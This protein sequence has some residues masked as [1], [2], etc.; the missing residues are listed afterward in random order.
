MVRRLFGLRMRS[1]SAAQAHVTYCSIIDAILPRLRTNP[2]W[3]PAVDNDYGLAAAI[4]LEE[5]GEHVRRSA[6]TAI[7]N[8]HDIMLWAMI[9]STSSCIAS[10]GRI[11]DRAPLH[12][13]PLFLYLCLTLLRHCGISC[14]P[15][16]SRMVTVSLQDICECTFILGSDR[17]KPFDRDAEI[18][19]ALSNVQ[20]SSPSLFDLL[21]NSVQHH[22]DYSALSPLAPMHQIFLQL[23]LVTIYKIK[24]NS[25]QQSLEGWKVYCAQT[26]PQH[27]FQCVNEFL[28]CPPVLCTSVSHSSPEAS[29]YF[30][31]GIVSLVQRQREALSQ[32]HLNLV[33]EVTY[34]AC[35][36]SFL[37]PYGDMTAIQ[38][39]A[40][41]YSDLLELTCP[42]QQTEFTNRLALWWYWVFYAVD[43]LNLHSHMK[44]MMTKFFSKKTITYGA[45][46]VLHQVD[47]ACPKHWVIG[48]IKTYCEGAP[49]PLADIFKISTPFLDA[50]VMNFVIEKNSGRETLILAPLFDHFCTVLLGRKKNKP[51]S[52][53]VE[54]L[55][56]PL[57]SVFKS[58][59]ASNR[60]K[61]YIESVHENMVT[62]KQVEYLC[63][64][65]NTQYE[66]LKCIEESLF[67]SATL[68]PI[69]TFRSEFARLKDELVSL[70][71][72]HS[73]LKD[74]HVQVPSLSFTVEVDKASLHDLIVYVEEQKQAIHLPDSLRNS[75]IHFVVNHS[76]FFKAIFLKKT[77][78]Q[79]ITC[80]KL[81]R[82]ISSTLDNLQNLLTG[83]IPLQEIK[84]LRQFAGKD[85]AKEIQLLSKFWENTGNPPTSIPNLH[86]SF[87]LLDYIQQL[88][89]VYECCE[90]YNVCSISASKLM[91]FTSKLNTELLAVDELEKIVSTIK[92]AVSGMKP[93]HLSIFG[94]IF[95]AED[96][97]NWYKQFTQ[98][99]FDEKDALVRASTQG[100]SF[101]QKLHL[102][103]VNAQKPLMIFQSVCQQE[104]SQNLELSI[105]CQ[106]LLKI[107]GGDNADIELIIHNISIVSENIAQVKLMFSQQSALSLDSLLPC[108]KKLRQD[109]QYCS[110]LSLH[111]HGEA[112][113]L[114]LK[115]ENRIETHA[116]LVDRIK[117]WKIFIDK[118]DVNTSEVKQF[119][120]IFSRAEK[121]HK[122]RL[123][124]EALGYPEI[125][126]YPH[127]P[128][129][130][131]TFETILNSPHA[132]M[133][134]EALKT[135]K[136]QLEE[137]L[138]NWKN[139]LDEVCMHQNRLYFL[140]PQQITMFSV[141]L[142]LFHDPP[143]SNK[144]S[145][146]SIYPYLWACFPEKEI[147][148]PQIIPICF[149][150]SL[151]IVTH[152]LGHTLKQPFSQL[153]VYDLLQIMSGFVTCCEEYLKPSP[154]SNIETPEQE[155][156]AHQQ[157]KIRV[158][159]AENFAPNEQLHLLFYCFNFQPPHP[160]C[161]MY[162]KTTTKLQIHHFMCCV[163]RFPHL[164]FAIVGVNEMV[165][166][167]RNSLFEWCNEKLSKEEPMAILFLI[168]T[169]SSSIDHFTSFERK[170]KSM[171]LDASTKLTNPLQLE[172]ISVR[173]RFIVKIY[174]GDARSGK[175]TEI[176]QKMRLCRQGINSCVISITEGFTIQSARKQLKTLL[177]Q[178]PDTRNQD[179]TINIH[180][181]IS[182]YADF[183]LV[184]KLMYNLVMW[185][186][187]FDDKT[188]KVLALNIRP[189]VK[190]NMFVE[191]A[192][193]PEGEG[194]GFPSP[195]AVIQNIA[196][197]WHLRNFDLSSALVVRHCTC[198][199][200]VDEDSSLV[201]KFIEGKGMMRDIQ[202]F[203]TYLNQ[204]LLNQPTATILSK[205]FAQLH[206]HDVNMQLRYQQKH[207]VSL[208]ADRCK[209]LQ[210]HS[211]E[212]LKLLSNV[213]F[214][215][216]AEQM[217]SVSKLFD[218]F[219]DESISL[220]KLS[221][222]MD[223]QFF[224]AREHL[225]TVHEESMIPPLPT[226]LA[227]MRTLPYSALSSMHILTLEQA[228][229][230]TQLRRE[231]SLAFGVSNLRSIIEQ[232]QY[233]LTPDFALK[234]LILYDHMKAGHN[235]TLCGGT[236]TGKTELLNIFSVIINA[237]TKLVPDLLWK[238]HKFV[239][240]KLV[241]RLPISPRD[242]E[243]YSQLKF[244]LDPTTFGK[245]VMHLCSLSPMTSS[246]VS[247]R[248]T[249]NIGPVHSTE[250]PLPDQNT[251]IFPYVAHHCIQFIRK[252][253]EKNPHIIRSVLLGRVFEP[254][255]T[256]PITLQG[257]GYVADTAE[258][259]IQILLEFMQAKFSSFF[260]RIRMHQKITADE[261][262]G[263]IEEIKIRAQNI[264]SEG[265]IVCFIDECTSTNILGMIKEVICDCQI[266][267][268]PLPKNIFFTA[269]L[270]KNISTDKSRTLL[271][272]SLNSDPLHFDFVGLHSELANK[273]FAVR[274]PPLSLETLMFDFGKFSAQQEKSFTERLISARVLYSEQHG[275]EIAQ[276]ILLGQE[277]LRK[278]NIHRVTASIRDIVRAV[279]LYIYF[280][281]HPQFMHGLPPEP[282][283][284][285]PEWKRFLCAMHWQAL[286]LSIAMNYFFRLP[287]PEILEQQGTENLNV[288]KNS[289]FTRVKFQEELETFLTSGGVLNVPPCLLMFQDFIHAVLRQVCL[290]TELPLGIAKTNAFMENLF[291]T[292][293][294]L[295]AKIPLIIVGPPGCSKTLSFKIAADNMKGRTSKSAFYRK[296]HH[297][298][299][300]R[301]QCS[302]QSTDIEIKAVYKAAIQRENTFGSQSEELCAVML[303]EVGLPNEVE[304]PLKI[305]HFKLDHPKV[306]SVLLSNRILDEAK[307]NR[308]LMLLQSEPPCDDL[309]TLAE[310]CL[311]GDDTTIPR[312][313]KDIL[314]GLCTAYLEEVVKNYGPPYPSRFFHLR[315]F[316]Y[317]LRYLHKYS[318]LNCNTFD[319]TPS[320][321]YSGLRRNFGG[322]DQNAFDSL[323]TTFFSHVNTAL[324]RN[325]CA[326]WTSPSKERRTEID[327]LQES[328][329]E[330]LSSEDDPNTSAFRYI[331]LLDP[332]DNEV[333]VQ[334]LFDLTLCDKEHTTV[335]HVSDFRDD[336]DQRVKATVVEQVK[337]AM[338]TGG[339]IILVNSTT[340]H[341]S[342]YDVFN[343]H[344]TVMFNS[345]DERNKDPLKR[346]RICYANLAAGSFTQPCIVHDDFR[347]IVHVP[348]NALQ[349][350]PT[351]LLNRFEKYSLS[352]DDALFYQSSCLN[353]K[354]INSPFGYAPPFEVLK[355]GVDR[356]VQE[357]H[358]KVSNSRLLCG[359]NLSETVCSLI[360]LI[361]ERTKNNA[362]TAYGVTNFDNVA[363]IFPPHLG[364]SSHPIKLEI[365]NTH[366]LDN[367]RD[368]LAEA[369]LHIL[370]LAK[371][372]SIYFCKALPKKYLENYLLK[373]EHFSL[374]RFLG[375][376]LKDRSSCSDFTSKWCI[377][378]RTSPELAHLSTN[379]QLR[380]RLLE[381]MNKTAILEDGVTGMDIFS[382]SDFGSS[383]H[384]VEYVHQFGQSKTK[385]LLLCTV[386]TA[387]CSTSQINFLRNEINETWKGAVETERRVAVV[388]L[389]FPPEIG[390]VTGAYQAIFQRGWDFSYIDSLGILPSSH[391][392]IEDDSRQTL[393]EVNPRAWLTRA[394]G[395]SNET[396]LKQSTELGEFCMNMTGSGL[397]A[398]P[399]LTVAEARE[400][401]G[402]STPSQRYDILRK[403]F[404][405]NPPLFQGI[406]EQF[407]RSWSMDFL[408][409]LVHN[410]SEEICNGTCDKSFVGVISSS[411]HIFMVP[412]MKRMLGMMLSSYGLN[413]I[414]N[415]F[416]ENE[417][418]AEIMMEL[419]HYVYCTIP[420]PQ[421][422]QAEF[423]RYR[424][425]FPAVPILRMHPFPSEL[426]FYDPISQL[427]LH[428]IK[429]AERE[430]RHTNPTPHDLYK[431]TDASIKDD[432]N[433]SSMLEHI[434][435][436]PALL[437]PFEQDYLM[438]S[439]KIYSLHPLQ[440]KQ[441]SESDVE[442]NR[443]SW[444]E[445]LEIILGLVRSYRISLLNDIPNLFV[446][447]RFHEHDIS[448]FRT[449]MTPLQILDPPPS[450]EQIQS[451]KQV[452]QLHTLTEMEQWVTRN[453][454]DLL[455]RRL[456]EE[457]LPNPKSGTL[458][459]NWGKAYRRF[460][461]TLKPRNSLEIV[462]S[463]YP[464][465]LLQLDCLRVVFL[466]LFD[467]MKIT[468]LDPT[469]PLL[470]STRFVEIL[471]TFTNQY[472]NAADR[473]KNGLILVSEL[474]L[475]DQICCCSEAAHHIFEYFLMEFGKS[476]QGMSNNCKSNLW[477]FLKLCNQTLAESESNA[478][479]KQVSGDLSADFG[480]TANFLHS[481]IETKSQPW[482]DE[483]YSLIAEVIAEDIHSFNATKYIYETSP[484]SSA[485]L[486][487]I[488]AAYKT[489]GNW[490][491]AG[492]CVLYQI[493]KAAYGV[494]VVQ[495]CA[496]MLNSGVTLAELRKS[497]LMDPLSQILASPTAPINIKKF[498]LKC[499]SKEQLVSSLVQDQNSLNLLG[500]PEMYYKRG[501][502]SKRFRALRDS[503]S[504]FC[505]VS[506]RLLTQLSSK[507]P[508]DC[509]LRDFLHM[510][511]QLHAITHL[512][513]LVTFYKHI[514][515]VFAPL[516][517][518][519]QLH[520]S[521]GECVQ[522][523]VDTN[524]EVQ[525]VISR[526]F[527][528]FLAAWRDSRI[529]FR[530]A[531]FP[532]ITER[533][534][535]LALVHLPQTGGS[536]I[537]FRMVTAIIDTQNKLI[538]LRNGNDNDEINPYGFLFE[539]YTLTY[540]V[541]F[542]PDSPELHLLVPG[543][544][545]DSIAQ[546]IFPYITFSDSN[547]LNIAE[548]SKTL[549]KQIIGKYLAGKVFLSASTFH[550]VFP[551]ETL[552]DL[553]SCKTVTEP[554]VPLKTPSMIAAFQQE[555]DKLPKE[556]H[557]EMSLTLQH[558]LEACLHGKN[559][560]SL[561]SLIVQLSQIAK[562]LHR[563]W[564]INKDLHNDL[565]CHL[566]GKLIVKPF[567]FEFECLKTQKSSILKA[568]AVL[569]TQKYK[570]KDWL[571]ANLP[572]KF[573]AKPS[574]AMVEMLQRF[575]DEVKQ[576][577]VEQRRH[578]LNVIEL[579][580]HFLIPE[581]L[582]T[583]GRAIAAE[584]NISTLF[585]DFSL[586]TSAK[587]SKEDV[588][589]I[590]GSFLVKHYCYLMR[591]LHT[592]SGDLFISISDEEEVSQNKSAIEYKELPSDSAQS[593]TPPT[594]L[595]ASNPQATRPGSLLDSLFEQDY[596]DQAVTIDNGPKR[597]NIN[598]LIR[599][600]EKVSEQLLEIQGVSRDNETKIVDDM[601]QI[602]LALQKIDLHAN[603]PKFSQLAIEAHIKEKQANVLHEQF[604]KHREAFT[605]H[606]NA[607]NVQLANCQAS[608]QVDASKALV[609][610]RGAQ[611]ILLDASELAEKTMLDVE[612]QVNDLALDILGACP[613]PEELTRVNPQLCTSTSP[614]PTPLSS[615]Q[616][617]QPTCF[618]PLQ[619]LSGN[620]HAPI[621]PSHS[622]NNQPTTSRAP[623]PQYIVPPLHYPQQPPTTLIRQQALPPGHPLTLQP[624]PP[625]S[626]LPQQKQPL[627][628]PL[629][630]PALSH[631]IPP[632]Y[633]AQPQPPRQPAYPPP[634][635]SPVPPVATR[636]ALPP[637]AFVPQQR[638]TVSYM[639]PQP[640][641]YIPHQPTSPNAAAL[642]AYPPPGRYIFP[643]NP[644]QPAAVYPVLCSNPPPNS[645]LHPPPTQPIPPQ[646]TSS[647]PLTG[648]ILGTPKRF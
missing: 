292:V 506:W 642:P 312:S 400:F 204:N 347:V 199:F 334:L 449:L 69:T 552:S 16:T 202:R 37:L 158:L 513:A 258:D 173:G 65:D 469:F 251:S 294:C 103:V 614:S 450:K 630:P 22:L 368:Y 489:P 295:D 95:N 539:K 75:L 579:I 434:S 154:K 317:F 517:T 224:I 601:E 526:S 515:D 597:V 577:N 484:S 440:F 643:P 376:V 253:L 231:L 73:W 627:T 98:R 535:F 228:Q 172:N 365:D 346:K 470:S 113:F 427:V 533:T 267:G 622:F 583:Q 92:E 74:N 55:T 612:N 322:I 309:Q 153:P 238:L 215:E 338:E 56:L 51:A 284:D 232:Q 607:I 576:S 378:M 274:A 359:A 608:I 46:A 518:E 111:P 265:K 617:S 230:E 356:M 498:F 283:T 591:Q 314:A 117:A 420:I 234:L 353:L 585:G 97:L 25:I 323:A 216:N 276:T 91:T 481:W 60:I 206:V 150:Q 120:K 195:E 14:A 27:P 290:S 301:Y 364:D 53:S 119:A 163:K 486:K 122:M 18:V 277:F 2:T 529:S 236:G 86:S 178:V 565:L 264:P 169:S 11:S 412:L 640:Y 70:S 393:E 465:T 240:T 330:K 62:E 593:T 560:D 372:E 430:L 167:L 502:K 141:K 5:F 647:L 626:V 457:I 239:F 303:D 210:K 249:V 252:Y 475:P 307:T 482:V 349:K 558:R 500:I 89:S 208:M 571:F 99:E 543:E 288:Q 320:Q 131:Q 209:W 275:R 581:K 388:V 538:N 564:R 341:S 48:C 201:A 83:K 54:T 555:V 250:M 351:P 306:S 181:D 610:L 194:Q 426:P 439:L 479:L 82:I 425:V 508:T 361:L 256:Q 186:V 241:N 394:F 50:D 6:E 328:L 447:K 542:L 492:E 472:Y 415:I 297:I 491:T 551:L 421:L 621:Q 185:K 147:V 582:S 127:L 523:I 536:D 286:G 136:N 315:D 61:E 175:T 379:K 569:L 562:A 145:S 522:I 226:A 15:S 31:H 96:A 157:E 382:L 246:V 254:S 433:L 625:P 105:L 41:C 599:A 304:S 156:S 511:S 380:Q 34:W 510:K 418:H 429:L 574:S 93:A 527:T 213:E 155:T 342:F 184:G 390:S 544:D 623:P 12:N 207:F 444:E 391:H 126:G 403:M 572:D 419:V 509:L 87:L 244:P 40:K 441:L 316:V 88:P 452:P 531:E 52:F 149:K 589:Q 405:G 369:N 460:F 325:A 237:N 648:S 404:E 278:A 63:Q 530:Q 262:R 505:I 198:E 618:T 170:D 319:I 547:H 409:K 84:P 77:E 540:Y 268:N 595:V 345:E 480:W 205:F 464:K 17:Q 532:E 335:C 383:Q 375:L 64:S 138:R 101:G 568:T 366:W 371:P 193:S 411:L 243:E 344:Y 59:R 360:L 550:T 504:S 287:S 477:V 525:E 567:P 125:F 128:N 432:A 370:Q 271:P 471:F 461:C 333:A 501:S 407:S 107:T 578:I 387:R 45:A 462:L 453:M 20:F 638:T 545:P 584:W 385:K 473:L 33:P 431:K 152:K 398:C 604:K 395:I 187:I 455:W 620:P 438:R 553:V 35:P 220:C 281:R 337:T 563:R 222:D 112:L 594:D 596:E 615:S 397:A 641:V 151:P 321:V 519:K 121:I 211:E 443:Q 180:I 528:N 225:Q 478:F 619:Q 66:H 233:I 110:R 524:P 367:I 106:Q 624:A 57:V 435:S 78:S 495:K 203:V 71:I 58:Y 354:H 598:S 114:V 285:S 600:S 483:I 499:I 332:T 358:I 399:T 280:M 410:V 183:F 616:S 645:Q 561:R 263:R 32:A 336:S 227:F 646:M 166:E 76:S 129:Q 451:I 644:Q 257:K 381:L 520:L 30:L 467:T 416:N 637:S 23:L 459:V 613:D 219:V 188:G 566:W 137:I 428:H 632:H 521:I 516:L 197:L 541:E 628:G 142:A 384:C 214:A 534:P 497:G 9:Q 408:Y 218:L 94:A 118:N 548:N 43:K 148:A 90:K 414:L 587:V 310:G 605:G 590:T 493:T 130:K 374:F 143:K 191:L 270:N 260:Y 144:A 39:L 373:Q 81:P 168:F 146:E 324:A 68:P 609:L 19:E 512:P 402:L 386:D 3:R 223:T 132:L 326:L 192:A 248:S 635:P 44:I 36:G 327:V 115:P 494:H 139:T 261:F 13:F 413:P 221:L 67:H 514:N 247:K 392:L 424:D 343:R 72:T 362:A 363:P 406:L 102:C 639:P 496:S 140:S 116:Y 26:L 42:D 546:N 603:N 24:T 272:I 21:C 490:N 38:E 401:Y 189:N 313:T 160:S 580:C 302:E 463:T 282:D 100:W 311:Y 602:T 269:A 104:N 296:L 200:I 289:K 298:I 537:I 49:S 554:K 291:C 217:L 389:H 454:S 437:K 174:A 357:L 299:P 456:V 308:C 177:R 423:I 422:S 161:I 109:G 396:N 235:L 245:S 445:F 606:I 28:C 629:P 556:F 331:M 485:S 134:P 162:G 636:P 124:L 259:L 634:H 570:A 164:I 436:H 507:L 348:K 171:L 47:P 503:P 446:I 182:A 575:C 135:L 559:E 293:V 1:A 633:Q 487:E 557:A 229:D 10:L 7:F 339:T 196:I 266:D 588:L 255:L 29:L 355:R 549:R 448:Y 279:D 123:H 474:L 350:I 4:A 352:I 592:L 133:E 611:K 417:R 80:D 488:I 79:D 468:T 305:L 300:F 212:R 476:S 85:W 179:F 242:R 377:F 466:L 273:A 631:H 340:I 458:L 442:L 165:E 190:W 8:N 329:A 573:N 586:I 108:I 318:E 176:R 159:L